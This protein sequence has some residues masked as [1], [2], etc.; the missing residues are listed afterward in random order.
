MDPARLVLHRRD[1]LAGFPATQGTIRWMGEK[2][3]DASVDARIRQ[4]ARQLTQGL[5]PFDH[6][7]EVAAVWR[8]VLT[9]VRYLRD[10]V[11]VEYIADPVELDR[12]VEEGLAAEDC[13]GMIAYA[14]ALLAAMG[15]PSFIVAHGFD[16]RRPLGFSHCAALVVNPRTKQAIW[17]DPVG[18]LEFPG[19]FHLGDTVHQPGDPVALWDLDGRKVRMSNVRDL[20]ARSSGGTLRQAALGDVESYLRDASK[21]VQRTADQFGPWGALVSGGVKLIESGADVVLDELDPERKRV[22]PLA[23]EAARR[24]AITV[25]PPPPARAL[26][27]APGAPRLGPL[28]PEKRRAIESFTKPKAE[29]A[30][31]ALVGLGVAA[32]VVKALL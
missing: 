6:D 9:H 7:G 21:T 17:F 31:K 30:G 12:Q 28:T 23:S 15:I 4:R 24:G 2:V 14:L 20:F 25:P 26:S 5:P 10:P 8:H 11:G 32:L 27:L 29:G 18:A 1:F 3:R 19:R 13:E 16:P 22:P